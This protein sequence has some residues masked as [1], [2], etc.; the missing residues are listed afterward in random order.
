MS[1]GEIFVFIISIVAGIVGAFLTRVS[2]LPHIYTRGNAGIGL[3]RLA[4]AASVLWTAYVIQ[5]HG[6]PSIKGVYVAFYLVMAYS[7]TKVFGQLGSQL[8]GFR[9]RSDIYERKNLA[10][11]QFAAAFTLATGIVFGG[12]LWGEADPLSD[13]EGGW[14]IPMGF[15]LLGWG[16]LVLATTLYLWREP[17][18]FRRQI[19]QERDTA[20]ASS[21]AVYVVST[22]TIVFGGVAGDF[23]G[24]RHGILG[25][26]TIVLMLVWHEFIVY[27]ASKM[28]PRRMMRVLEQ[29]M[30]IGL[31]G[32]VWLLNRMIDRFYTGG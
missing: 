31:A 12:S 23:W 27:G 20:M 4:V 24:W 5:Y 22:S 16:T 9:L 3:L 10:G 29:S 26:G 32:V 6:D 11:A 14:W 25:M 19:C 7:I 28:A 21:A 17:G 1:D 18:L 13:A 2:S 8:F 15:F 30:Y